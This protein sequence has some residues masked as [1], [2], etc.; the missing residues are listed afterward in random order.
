MGCAARAGSTQP[1]IS[2]LTTNPSN[3]IKPR[4]HIAS[5]WENTYHRFLG[6]HPSVDFYVN[7]K[8]Q[9]E[10][11]RNGIGWPLNAAP[12]VYVVSATAWG[13]A[14]LAYIRTT[15]LYNNSVRPPRHLR[16]I[17]KIKQIW[18]RS[19]STKPANHKYV[20]G[21]AERSPAKMADDLFP[22]PSRFVTGYTEA[23][24]GIHP[25]QIHM[26]HP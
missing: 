8:S 6:R 2:G 26:A 9:S 22:I 10:A 4:T 16:Q 21:Q 11:C 3:L 20:P 24:F 23:S 19:K 25:L 17:L 5:T 13:Q 12:N 1:S 15:T 14:F 7:W 18:P